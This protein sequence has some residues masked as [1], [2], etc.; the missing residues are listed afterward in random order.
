MSIAGETIGALRLIWGVLRFDAQAPQRF[1]NTAEAARRSFV[2]GLLGMPIYLLVMRGSLLAVSPSPD[3]LSFLPPMLVFYVIEWLLWPNLM[4]GVCRWLAC[5]R[6]YCRY[7]AAYNWF[8]LT[9]MV[10]MLPF[11][12]AVLSPHAAMSGIALL[13]LVATVVFAVYEWFIARHALS[14]GGRAAFAVVML[15]LLAN[16]VLIQVKARYLA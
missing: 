1:A 10:L 6:F 8:A 9:Q 16:L 11:Q 7:V 14:I 12:M 4:V 5:E 15:N 2:A 3:V 13:G